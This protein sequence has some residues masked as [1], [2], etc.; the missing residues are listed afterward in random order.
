MPPPPL[1]PEV[2]VVG[3]AVT[4]FPAL[5][6]VNQLPP[7]AVTPWPLVS[8]GFWSITNVYSGCPLYVTC[9]FPSDRGVVP[10]N[11]AFSPVPAAVL[12]LSRRGGQAVA[13]APKQALFVPESFANM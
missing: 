7:N 3:C 12:P 13:Q 10:S 9:G 6:T 11:E 8:P 2:V 4:W 5:F 1:E